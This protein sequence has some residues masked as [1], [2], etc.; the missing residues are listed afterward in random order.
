MT[1]MAS[2]TSE[3]ATDSANSSQDAAF[4]RAAVVFPGQGAQKPGMAQDFHDQY[5]TSKKVFDEASEATGVDIAA[6][7]F[8]EEDP[9]LNLTEFTQ[10]CIL[11]AEIAVYRILEQE[12]NFKPGFFAGHSLGEYT[13]LVAAGVMNLGEAVQIVRKRGAL[14]QAAVPENVGAMAAIILPG[15]ENTNYAEI[16]AKH[17]AE[18]ANINS[19]EQVVISGSKEAV[20]AAGQELKEVFA[21]PESSADEDEAAN[22]GIDVRFLTVSAPFHSSLMKKIE[23]EFADYLK[24]FSGSFD[25]SGANKV[26]SNFT[27]DFHQPD[28]LLENLVNQISGPVRWVDNMRLLGQH[29]DKIFEV[30]P[31]RPLGKFF[32][33]GRYGSDLHHQPALG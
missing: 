22:E 25:L 4:D 5:E 20:Q 11:T 21:K 26:V 33:V 12:H 3:N 31:N 24:S 16:I 13:A 14:M 28:T 2:S 10:P 17:K 6:I 27:A 23:P 1:T 8:S 18:I 30:G 32:S 15:L 9:R 29:A 7:C 19:P